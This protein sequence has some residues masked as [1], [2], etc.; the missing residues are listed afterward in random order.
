MQSYGESVESAERD[1]RKREDH[2][3]ALLRSTREKGLVLHSLVPYDG[4]CLFHSVICLLPDSARD[5]ASLRAA[6]VQFFLSQRCSSELGA[7]A[8]SA[9]LARLAQPHRDVTD[10]RVVKGLAEHLSARIHVYSIDPAVNTETHLVYQPSPGQATT[11]I[12]IGHIKGEHYVPLRQQTYTEDQQLYQQ[13]PQLQQR[14]LKR[15]LYA[16]K[17]RSSKRRAARVP[18]PRT[19][20]VSSNQIL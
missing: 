7:T 12:N 9:F 18:F 10:D 17:D 15:P 6:L 1:R 3:W 14:Q 13:R 16:R 19:H 20:H 4:D 11:T 5:A 2:L 8:D